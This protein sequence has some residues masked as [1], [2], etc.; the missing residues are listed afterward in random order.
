MKLFL[1]KSVQHLRTPLRKHGFDLCESEIYHFADGERGYRLKE[2]LLAESVGVIGSVLP[3]PQSLFDLMALHQVVRENGVEEPT[4]IVPYLGYARQDRPGRPGEGAIGLMVIEILQA[5]KSSHLI[6]IDIHSDRIR[7]ALQPTVREL[8]A[9]PLFAKALSTYL[10]EVVV[11]PD[12]GYLSRARQLSGLFNPHLEVAFVEKERPRP[13]F[14]IARSLHG[15]VEG[16]TVIILDDIIDTGRTLVEAV[17]LVVRSGAKKVYLAAT[18]AIFSGEARKRLSSLPVEGIFVT[19]TLPQIRSPK[20]RI[21]DAALLIRNALQHLA[22]L[23][24]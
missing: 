14:A 6:L 17:K 22:T 3:D 5:I 21:L 13:N 23:S 19:N 20:V 4:L 15:N 8:S 18:H 1:T 7:K 16:K 24:A 2:Q 11:S 10:P 9:L 12:A